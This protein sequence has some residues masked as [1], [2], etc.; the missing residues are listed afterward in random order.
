MTCSHPNCT[1]EEKTDGLCSMHYQRRYHG[2]PMDAPPYGR[3]LTLKQRF[4]RLYKVVPS[5]CWEWQSKIDTKG[6]GRIKI[7]NR[8][9]G[10]HRVSYELYKENPEKMFVCHHCD[11]PKCVNP[12]HLFLGTPKDNTQDCVK[13]GRHAWADKEFLKEIRQKRKRYF[14]KMTEEQVEEIRQSKE[15]YRTLAKRFGVGFSY[16]GKIKRGE[17]LVSEKIVYNPSQQGG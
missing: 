1:F 3:S 9:L 15:S 14:S 7:K 2:R 6:Y 5:G 13:K 10:A 16:I 11:N 17:M 12:D 8:Y 4:E